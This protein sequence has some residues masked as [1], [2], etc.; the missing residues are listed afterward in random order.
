MSASVRSSMLVVTTGT[1][2]VVAAFLVGQ[3][4][5]TRGIRP[6]TMSARCSKRRT[7]QKTDETLVPTI[8]AACARDG[9]TSRVTP[10]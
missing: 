1:V 8:A 9:C 5:G 2:G 6:A 7:A 4:A 10:T 3:D